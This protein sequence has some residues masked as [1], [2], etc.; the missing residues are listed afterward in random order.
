MNDALGRRVPLL[1]AG[2]LCTVAALLGM[3]TDVFWWLLC[4]RCLF[5]IGMGINK[6]VA[7]ARV[8]RSRRALT[9]VLCAPLSLISASL[10]IYYA[11][12]TPKAERGGVVAMTEVFFAV[13]GIVACVTQLCLQGW[14]TSPQG[15]RN[16]WRLLVRC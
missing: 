3:T 7:C 14:L 10:A 5:G 13:G 9:R 6:C 15:Q 4:V 11:E 1:A 16:N 12:I 2:A 8:R